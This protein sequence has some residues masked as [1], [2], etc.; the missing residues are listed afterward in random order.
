[1]VVLFIYDKVKGTNRAFCL[2]L[3]TCNNAF[4]LISSFSWQKL[5]S[6]PSSLP[7]L[8]GI[9]LPTLHSTFLG[10][11]DIKNKLN[12]WSLTQICSLILPLPV[13]TSTCR[14]L[15]LRVLY[16]IV[17]GQNIFSGINGEFKAINHDHY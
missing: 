2:L 9:F 4:F 17:L 1:M 3:P 11:N 16:Y 5:N 14:P 13:M 6:T 10:S 12:L 8:Y 7:L 15:F